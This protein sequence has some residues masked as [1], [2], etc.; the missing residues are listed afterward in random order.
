MRRRTRDAEARQGGADD[1]GEFSRDQSGPTRRGG[2]RQRS[3]KGSP[4]TRWER[5]GHKRNFWSD[6]KVYSFVKIHRTVH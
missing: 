5:K 1:T 6:E 4:G 3:V 2:Q